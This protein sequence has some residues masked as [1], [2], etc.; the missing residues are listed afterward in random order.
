MV[1]L[2]HQQHPSEFVINGNPTNF[3]EKQISSLLAKQVKQ[4]LASSEGTCL[5]PDMA[6]DTFEES[7]RCS[8]CYNVVKDPK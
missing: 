4:H 1:E 5:T 6:A 7:F 3:I 2:I 8:I